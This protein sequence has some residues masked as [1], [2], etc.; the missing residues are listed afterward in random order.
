MSVENDLP[1][2]TPPTCTLP[3][4][5]QPLR[6]AEF[7]NLFRECVTAVDRTDDTSLQLTLHGGDE[8]DARVRD[9]TARETQCCSFFT[10]QLTPTSNDLRLQ[11]RVPHERIAVLDAFATRAEELAV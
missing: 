6:V 10:F 3:I 7:D 2:W 1:D 4:A 11:V 5:Q 9:L 8:V